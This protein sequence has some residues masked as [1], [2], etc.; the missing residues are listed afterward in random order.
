MLFLGVL[1]GVAVKGSHALYSSVCH[2]LPGC[3]LL[4]R[5]GFV[6]IAWLSSGSTASHQNKLLTNE[7]L[8]NELLTNAVSTATEKMDK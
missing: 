5:S 2:N 4:V 3:A 1:G 8:T 6:A 7:L